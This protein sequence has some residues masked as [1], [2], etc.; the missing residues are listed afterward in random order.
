MVTQ[1]VDLAAFNEGELA[2]VPLLCLVHAPWCYLNQ[3][4]DICLS[5][6]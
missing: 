6:T 3:P 1:S 5:G 4:E 2:D